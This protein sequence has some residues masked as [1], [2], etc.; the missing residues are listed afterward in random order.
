MGTRMDQS[1][2]PDDQGSA[3]RDSHRPIHSDW[4]TVPPFILTA[5]QNAHIL[6]GREYAPQRALA[7]LAVHIGA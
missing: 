5:N 4:T 2:T 7:R 6:I 1:S 3:G